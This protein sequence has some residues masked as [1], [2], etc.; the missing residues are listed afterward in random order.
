MVGKGLGADAQLVARL[1]IAAERRGCDE[2]L[3]RALARAAFLAMSRE[4][5]RLI[6]CAT[7]RHM[8][9]HHAVAL[10]ILERAAR[11]VDRDLMEIGRAEP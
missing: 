11:R 3:R 4:A 6:I 10:E 2:A 7:L 9:L 5:V 1:V 8:H